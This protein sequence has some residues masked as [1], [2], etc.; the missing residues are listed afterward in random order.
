MRNIMNLYYRASYPDDPV[1]LCKKV[2]S[3]SLDET[4]KDILIF[5]I[6]LNS[7]IIDGKKIEDSLDESLKPEFRKI[8]NMAY[9][10]LNEWKTFIKSLLGKEQNLQN[11]YLS[12]DDLKKY[13]EHYLYKFAIGKNNIR[14]FEHKWR[15]TVYHLSSW[16]MQS[17]I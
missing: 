4:R 13:G 7:E 9:L 12:E 17:V 6:A 8:Y 3:E 15:E 10:V 2:L 11:L 16:K 1:E 14:R 5:T